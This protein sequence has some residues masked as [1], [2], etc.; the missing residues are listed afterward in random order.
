MMIAPSTQSQRSAVIR[1]AIN[2]ITIFSLLFIYGCSKPRIL[3]CG[4]DL[5]SDQHF[6]KELETQSD[7]QK[8]WDAIVNTSAN[9][10][11]QTPT[12]KKLIK[13]AIARWIKMTSATER[14]AAY[15]SLPQG[16]AELRIMLINLTG[17]FGIVSSSAEGNT[18]VNLDSISGDAKKMSLS[19]ADARKLSENHKWLSSV[20]DSMEF[21]GFKIYVMQSTQSLDH[22]PDKLLV[23]PPNGQ[24]YT[25]EVTTAMYDMKDMPPLAQ[26]IHYGEEG[27]IVLMVREQELGGHGGSSSLKFYQLETG[28]IIPRIDSSQGENTLTANYE[29]SS[30]GLGADNYG[31]R[32]IKNSKGNLLYAVGTGYHISGDPTDA[33]GCFV[34][35]KYFS[36]GT[37]GITEIKQLVEKKVVDCSYTPDPP[38]KDV[39]P[40]ASDQKKLDKVIKFYSEFSSI[41]SSSAH[42]K[43]KLSGWKMGSQLSQLIDLNRRDAS[44]EILLNIVK[45]KYPTALLALAFAAK[46]TAKQVDQNLSDSSTILTTIGQSFEK[47]RWIYRGTSYLPLLNNALLTP[48]ATLFGLKSEMSS[49]NL[50]SDEI[51][52]AEEYQKNYIF[53]RGIANRELPPDQWTRGDGF[54]HA[55]E[56]IEFGRMPSNNIAIL[57]S[58]E[59]ALSGRGYF[60]MLVKKEGMVEATLNDGG[61]QIQVPEYSVAP[62]QVIDLLSKYQSNQP[63]IR[64]LSVKVDSFYGLILN[65]FDQILISLGTV[66]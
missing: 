63:R 8:L 45:Q 6:E 15:T 16:A 65:E 47:L 54:Q 23:V 19:P 17:A 52:D 59:P 60:S 61:F 33:Q 27:R 38:H 48:D 22:N 43:E 32:F 4:P 20:I 25:I 9:C 26:V 50:K 30:A 3:A 10:P 13:D 42:D 44:D 37:V 24:E 18:E 34:Y 41:E 35:R 14:R 1:R 66:S 57:L 39:S 62:K 7:S 40:D 29:S 58:K 11:L 21:D 12:Q 31:L 51:A 28:K 56:V 64:E 36:L 5:N 2:V 55:Y 53:L 49:I 46:P